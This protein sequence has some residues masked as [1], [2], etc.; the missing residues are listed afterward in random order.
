[1]TQDR[2]D[3]L[4]GTLQGTFT[5]ATGSLADCTCKKGS[6][7]TITCSSMR[8]PGLIATD[9]V[10]WEHERLRYQG[11]LSCYRVKQILTRHKVCKAEVRTVE[12]IENQLRGV[13]VCLG[14][15]SACKKRSCK[16]NPGYQEY[17]KER[18][19]ARNPEQDES[20]QLAV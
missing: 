20:Q 5:S 7:L 2:F 10:I 19:S 11:R 13:Q 15:L 6:T 1:M 8:N 16:F 4:V 17:L 3:A 12:D 9:C 14:D 18:E